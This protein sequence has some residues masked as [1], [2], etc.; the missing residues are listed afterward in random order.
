VIVLPE[1]TLEN[2]SLVAERVRQLVERHPFQYEGKSYP[3]TVSVG[4]S[5]TD[6]GQPLTPHD[7][8]RQADEKLYLAKNAGRNRVVA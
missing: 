7:L 4:V 8:I 3:V 1:T 2:G 6:G 5:A